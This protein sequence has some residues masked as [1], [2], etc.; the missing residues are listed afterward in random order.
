ML[1]YVLCRYTA[2]TIVFVNSIDAIRRL[3]PILSYLGVQVFGLHAEMQQRQR[4]KNLDR[5]VS[6]AILG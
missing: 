3:V 5:L 1:Y 4:L 2:K 6:F